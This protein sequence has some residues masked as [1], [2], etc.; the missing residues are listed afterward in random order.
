M[1]RVLLVIQHGYPS[2]FRDRLHFFPVR[3]KPVSILAFYPCECKHG[4]VV[5][6]VREVRPF[7]VRVLGFRLLS[8]RLMKVSAKI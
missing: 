4:R 2:G 1:S 5:N 3:L 8:K 6:G 7:G